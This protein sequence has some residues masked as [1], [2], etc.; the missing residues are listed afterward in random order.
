MAKS[1]NPNFLLLDA[2]RMQPGGGS[3]LPNQKTQLRNHHPIQGK[4]TLWNTM[5]FCLGVPKMLLEKMLQFYPFRIS[6]TENLWFSVKIWRFNHGIHPGRLTW[7]LKISQL[8][9][10][11]IFQTISFRFHVNLPGCKLHKLPATCPRFPPQNH[12]TSKM[13]CA[14]R[15]ENHRGFPD[16]GKGNLTNKKNGHKDVSENSV[17]PKSSIQK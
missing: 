5:A 10:K 3:E 17:T 15:T 16:L 6:T 9:R 4:L 13:R 12:R 2:V 7:N 11:I 8:K 14:W 1:S